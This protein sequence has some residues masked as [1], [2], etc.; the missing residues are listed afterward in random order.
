ME[1]SDS[2]RVSAT[3][4]GVCLCGGGGDGKVHARASEEVR[5]GR[6]AYAS[7]GRRSWTSPRAVPVASS[8]SSGE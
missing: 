6:S 8:P 1:L 7:F 3:P 5:L 4:T 2:K